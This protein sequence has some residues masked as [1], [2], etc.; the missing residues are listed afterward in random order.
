MQGVRAQ[1]DK[2]YDKAKQD[3]ARRREQTK[4]LRAEKARKDEKSADRTGRGVKRSDHHVEGVRVSFDTTL[5]KKS[6]EI[7]ELKADDSVKEP[8]FTRSTAVCT[9]CQP[10]WIC[11]TQRNDRQMRNH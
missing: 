5:A 2:A 7:K 4:A 10:L 11:R 9:M 1:S 8:D 3:A 6:P